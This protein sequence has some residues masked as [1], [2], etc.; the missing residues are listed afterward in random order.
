M[1]ARRRKPSLS[2]TWRKPSMKAYSAAC[3]SSSSM[4][5]SLK[6][7]W[8]VD[9]GF[10]LAHFA[11]GDQRAQHIDD[12]THAEQRGDVRSVIGRRDLDHLETAQA[13]GRHLTDQAQYL[14]RQEAARL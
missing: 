5:A 13:L 11:V 12:D 4:T 8:L 7:H 10:V 14:A 1:R 3:S 6:L 9:D 2:E